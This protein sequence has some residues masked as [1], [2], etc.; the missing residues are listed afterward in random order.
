MTSA[1]RSRKAYAIFPQSFVD[2]GELLIPELQKR[3]LVGD[4]Y[5]VQGGTYRENFYETQGQTYPRDD[6][7]AST[8]HWRNGVPAGEHKIPE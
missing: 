4:D 3:G 5:A 1:N 6:H 8:Y 7:V 2:I